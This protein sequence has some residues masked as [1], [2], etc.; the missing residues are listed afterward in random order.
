M[1]ALSNVDIGR[2]IAGNKGIII[3]NMNRDHLTAPGYDLTIG[4]I[5]D[6][7]TGKEPEKIECIYDRKFDREYMRSEFFGDRQLREEY[8]KNRDEERYRPGYR[9]KLMPGK[10]YLVIS[11]EYVALLKKYMAVL[12]SRGSYALKGIVVTSTIID[13]NYSGFIYASLVN[14]SA[15][16]VYIKEHNQF[17]TMVVHSLKTATDKTLPKTEGGMP[18]DAEQTLNGRFS[19]VCEAATTAAKRYRTDAWKKIEQQFRDQYAAFQ[20]SWAGRAHFPKW[21]SRTKQFLIEKVI[22]KPKFWVG[23]GILILLLWAFVT[24][25]LDKVTE[26]AGKLL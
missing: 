19:N 1:A 15:E 5:C 7:D 9:Y 4:F 21:V 3:M 14:C 6:S 13:P 17:A 24:E 26:V 22:F 10:R 18:R 25:G 2:I 16:P 8:E 20:S 23:L 12:Y 11:E